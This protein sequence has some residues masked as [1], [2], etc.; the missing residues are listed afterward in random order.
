MK[1]DKYCS[2]CGEWLGNYVTGEAPEGTASYYSLIRRKYCPSCAKWKR[3]LDYRFYC[4]E[5]HKKKK[6]Q[7][8]EL[9]HQLQQLQAENKAL[10]EY[11]IELRE[12]AAR[13]KT[14]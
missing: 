6:K 8:K 14:S 4:A 7:N 1:G 10:R 3:T 2:I 13:F 9:E 5:Y 11:I 12:S